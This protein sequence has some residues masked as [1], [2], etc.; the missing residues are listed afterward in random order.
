MVDAG[1]GAIFPESMNDL[2]EFEAITNAI[3]VL[4]LT[5]VTVVGRSELFT[6][7]QLADAGVAMIIYPVTLL[8]SA[9]GAA[10]RVLDTISE[11]DTQQPAVGEMLT[12]SRL[13]ELVAYED[14]NAFDSGI[15]NF[16]V[17]GLD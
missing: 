17:P 2:S 15:F 12:R 14:Y 6:R 9:M 1:A 7:Q 4:V 5:N 11:N 3:V 13:Y 16:E 10:E 8:R